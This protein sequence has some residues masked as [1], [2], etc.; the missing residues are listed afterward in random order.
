[1]E[2]ALR[3]VAISIV[4]APKLQLPREV[5]HH[6]NMAR[7]CTIRRECWDRIHQACL[8]TSEG[9]GNEPVAASYLVSCMLLVDHAGAN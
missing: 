9:S 6:W 4:D 5:S 7:L 2:L 8:V 3:G 1:M